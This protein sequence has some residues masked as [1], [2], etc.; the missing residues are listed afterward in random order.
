MRSLEGHSLNLGVSVN[1]ETAT[2]ESAPVL[3]V[4]V[5]DD[6]LDMRV[7][8]R[9]LLKKWGY[10]PVLASN[11]A[12]GLRLIAEEDI[13]LVLLD[14]MMDGMSGPEVCG[15]LRTTDL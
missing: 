8:L 2:T 4:L 15:Q 14:W 13:R 9:A 3:K 7:Y 1:P 12:D 10:E 6:A 5:V 11:G